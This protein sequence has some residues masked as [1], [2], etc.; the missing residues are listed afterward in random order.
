MLGPRRNERKSTQCS[1][2]KKEGGHIPADLHV[3]VA[4][5]VLTVDSEGTQEESWA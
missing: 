5:A 2:N 1:P 4:V 3:S